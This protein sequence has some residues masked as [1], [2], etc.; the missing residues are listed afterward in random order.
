MNIRVYSECER[1]LQPS[2]SL[3]PDNCC[4]IFSMY[5][6]TPPYLLVIHSIVSSS[7]L[8]LLKYII[9]QQNYIIK[10]NLLF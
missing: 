9:S 2:V 3:E 8:Y 5:L 4:T 10:L 7:S 1:L 6:V